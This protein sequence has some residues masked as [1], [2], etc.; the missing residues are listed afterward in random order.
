MATITISDLTYRRLQEIAEA[1]SLSL[2]A[3]LA[4]VA[5]EQ[6][7]TPKDSRRQLAAIES[8][9]AGMTTWTSTHLPPGHVV[10]DSR[11]TIYEGRGG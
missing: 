1:R 5:A 8:F 4:E 9:T 3:Y 10:D 7:P 2:D 6:L 11:E